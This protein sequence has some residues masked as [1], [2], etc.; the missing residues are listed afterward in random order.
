[1]TN[2]DIIKNEP[3]RTEGATVGFIEATL[4]WDPGRFAVLLRDWCLL[5]VLILRGAGGLN[6]GLERLGERLGTR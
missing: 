5:L 1:M 3:T 6:A 4:V 2:E